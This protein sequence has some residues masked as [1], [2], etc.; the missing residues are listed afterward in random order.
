MT[1][2]TARHID[3]AFIALLLA[4]TLAGMLAWTHACPVS[5]DDLP[6]SHV[7]P[8]NAEAAN[9]WVPSGI[10]IETFSQAWTSVIHHRHLNGR[11]GDLVH[12]MLQPM[13]RWI[14]A[15][16]LSLCLCVFLGLLLIWQK[17]AGRLKPFG[18]ALAV[19]LLWT[20]FPWYDGFQALVFQANYVP[21]SALS[22]AIVLILTTGRLFGAKGI[23]GIAAMSFLTGWFHEAFGLSLASYTAVLW[24]LSKRQRKLSGIALLSVLAGVAT[25]MLAGTINRM[26]L[27]VEPIVFFRNHLMHFVTETWPV[28]LAA[29]ACVYGYRKAAKALKKDL[30]KDTLPLWGAILTSLL[31]GLR[32]AALG[33]VLWPALLYSV[34][35][36][37]YIAARIPLKAKPHLRHALMVMFVAAYGWWWTQIVKWERIVAEDVATLIAQCGPNR[38]GAPTVSFAEY[39]EQRKIPYY[40][41]GL[42]K[43]YVENRPE[44]QSLARWLTLREASVLV[45]PKELEDKPFEQWPY[46]GEQKLLRGRWP[47]MVA[48]DS[49][50][51]DFRLTVGPGDSNLPPLNRLMIAIKIIYTEN[52]DSIG[53]YMFAERVY[54]PDGSVAYRYFTEPLPRTVANRPM[55]AFDTISP[56]R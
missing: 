27:Q 48:R 12:I 23:V 20:A 1:A 4:V 21:A 30:L 41:L 36:I 40:L 44:A 17:T 33:R 3:N 8:D 6:F 18:A 34:L 9:S 56:T 51:L 47:M 10:P 15:A 16:L 29:L 5:S 7:L 2:K 54:M 52:L 55:A 35:C 37:L 26:T 13:P 19:V 46:I 22:T 53:G 24:L 11:L 42:A 25:N 39:T 49:L 32:L 31:I 38:K 43:S 50:N 14:G 45:L 28:A